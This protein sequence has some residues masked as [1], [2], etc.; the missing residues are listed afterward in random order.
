VNK[1]VFTEHGISVKAKYTD[2]EVTESEEAE[3]VQE[4]SG[5]DIDEKFKA[6]C[7]EK[8]YDHTEG[9]EL[10]KQIMKWQE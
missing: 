2:V 7:E 1:K 6:F 9:Y 10:L 5:T 4:L 8:G 3:A